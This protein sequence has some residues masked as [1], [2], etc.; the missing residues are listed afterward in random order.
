MS[1]LYAF[2]FK[3]DIL[4]HHGVDGQK[5]GVRN[6]PPYP[7]DRQHGNYSK[8]DIVFI[9]GTSKMDT[10]EEKYYRKTLPSAVKT[11]LDSMMKA[12][13]KILVGDCFGADDMVQLYLAGNRYR[14]VEIYVT[15]KE[16]RHNRDDGKLGWKVHHID[17]SKYEKGSTEWHAVKDI[18]MNNAATRGLAIILDNGAK[19]TRK[20]ID[21][22]LDESKPCYI[23]A[24]D[25][26]GEN[27]DRPMSEG[28]YRTKKNHG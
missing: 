17:G 2:R 10:P 24:L 7:L 3:E 27:F 5:W 19:A 16:V 14:N 18:A 12:G 22:F 28:L 15:G 9:S 13:S 21:R 26:R 6:G 23:Y 25:S 20:N 11:E 1:H 8:N 4:A